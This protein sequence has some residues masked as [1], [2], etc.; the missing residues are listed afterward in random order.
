MNLFSTLG[1][2]PWIKEPELPE[3]QADGAT[4]DALASARVLLRFVLAIVGVLF[5]LF[6]ITFLSRSQYPDWISLSGAPWQPFS[7]S[8]RLWMNTLILVG[9]SLALHASVV[10]LR[11]GRSNQ[12]SIAIGVAAFLTCGFLLAQYT[13]WLQLQSLGFYMSDNVANSYFYLLTAV[14]GLHLVVGLLVMA[15][16][17]LRSQATEPGGD[18]AGLLSLCAT[19]WHFLLGVW[20]VL[21]ALLTSP[22]ET[23]D[24]LAALCGF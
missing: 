13:L 24:A 11:R 10:A 1:E 3:S 16:V 5:F 19:Y 21:F 2:K 20:L 6:I 4:A 15:S 14:H 7:D 9:A 18:L 12:A 8:S 23:I 17:L 22:P